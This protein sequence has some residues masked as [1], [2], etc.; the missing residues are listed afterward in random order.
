MASLN[1]VFLIGNLTRDPEV[2]A[3]PSGD[4]VAEMGI[5]VTEVYRSR[6]GETRESTV[7]AD[8]SAW[9]KTG[10]NCGKYL[11]KGSPI[12]VEG[13]LVL[14]QWEDKEGKKRS[15]LRIRAE[16]VQFL[17][18]G[19]RTTDRQQQADPSAP[20]ADTSVPQPAPYIPAP[21]ADEDLADLP[22]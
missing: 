10:E 4:K 21:A 11:T 9:G 3:L 2:R 6:T 16:R 19:Q 8:V 12:F 5:A 22:F 17:S 1:K 14:D 15:R 13:R 18:S 7:F 20:T